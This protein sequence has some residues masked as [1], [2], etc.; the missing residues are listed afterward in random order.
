M[1]GKILFIGENIAHVQNLGSS[2][3]A[4]DLMNVNVIFEAPD[5]RIL[6]EI[7]EVNPD[8]FKI[9]FLGEYVDGRYVNGVIRKP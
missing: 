1:F 6:G 2:N 9:R 4:A 7:T 5:Q 3:A 8:L